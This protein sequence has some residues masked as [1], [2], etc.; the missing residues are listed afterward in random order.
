MIKHR[1]KYTLLLLGLFGLMSCSMEQGSEPFQPEEMEE[2]RE[3]ETSVEV[4]QS[5]LDSAGVK[6]S[7][8]VLDLAEGRYYSNDF[9]WAKRGNLPASTYKITNSMIALETGVLEDDSSMFIWN[10]EQR[11]LRRWEQD[12]SLKNAFHYSCVPCYQEVA[13]SIGVERMNAYL[14]K[15]NYGTMDVDST[16]IDM[17]WLEGKSRISQFEQVDFLSRFYRSELPI[18]ERTEMIMKRMMIIEEREDFRLT[19]KTG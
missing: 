18:E 16:T 11:R 19:G 12:L 15:L 4:F 9:E 6:G 1:M 17:F 8:L 5:L 7:I 10:G 2:V 3:I 14:G 13:R